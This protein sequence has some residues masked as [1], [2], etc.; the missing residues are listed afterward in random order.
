MSFASPYLLLTLVAVPFVAAGYVFLERVR[1]RRA[2]NWASPN[3]M[4]NMQAATPGFRRHIPAALFLI[5]LS[6]LLV[7]F[8]RPEATFKD[9]REGATVVL[10]VDVSGSMAAKDL[11]PTRSAAAR[12][13]MLSFLDELPSKYRVALVSFSD[14]SAVLVPPTYDRDRLRAA[15]PIKTFVAGTAIGDAVA[16]SVSVAVRAIGPAKPGDKRPPASVLLLSDGVQTAGRLSPDDAAAVA[17]K[18]GIPVSTVLVGTPRG[19]VEQ[20]IPGGT[21]VIQVPADPTTLRTVAQSSGGSFFAARSAKELR[22]VYD[23]LGSR[24]ARENKRH[25]ITAGAAGLA[26]LFVVAGALLSGLWFRRIV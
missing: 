13:A 10:A 23:D 20:P 8:A 22:R 19:V 4:P 15:L 5:A 18:A 14:H 17:R 2:A 24:S 21:N 11:K 1:G 3:L 16:R 25:E 12:T 6:L 7:G 26:L 9:I